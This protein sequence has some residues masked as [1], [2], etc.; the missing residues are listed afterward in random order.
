MSKSSS[1]P[2]GLFI[3]FE[4]IE[5]VGKT[6]QVQL[7]T[8]ALTDLAIPCI[9]TREPGG[10]SVGNHIRNCLL[11]NHDHLMMPQT[12]MCL[13]LAARSDHWHHV[14]KPH[15]QKGYVVII[16]RFIDASVAYQGYGR[17]LGATW[18]KNLHDSLGL[19]YEPDLTFLLDIDVQTSKKRLAT[20]GFIDRIEKEE[21]NFFEKVRQGYLVE[22]KASKRTDIISAQSE[23]EAIA[24]RI[25]SKVKTKMIE[26]GYD[27]PL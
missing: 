2:K 6:T 25:L 26:T 11:A 15:L 4:G 16:D 18:V 3:S 20:R 1:V 22:A 17:N 10:T 23:K 12:E 5:G 19:T 7:L 27:L 13:F 21:D 14:I 9:K 24:Q 8:E